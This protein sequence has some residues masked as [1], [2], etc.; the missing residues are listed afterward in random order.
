[1]Q[2]N[3]WLS[4]DPGAGGAGFGAQWEAQ[5]VHSV[6]SAIT[7]A[8]DSERSMY[9]VR[10]AISHGYN[11]NAFER[12]IYTESHDEDANGNSRVPEEIWP[13]NAGSYFSKKRSTLGAALVFTAPGIPMIFQGQEFLESGYFS[14]T[15]AL[16]WTKQQSFSGI[17]T[18]YRDMVRLRRNW[19][20]NTAG[21]KGQ[22]LNVFHVNDAE[23]VIAFHRWD[24][25]GPGDD[26]VV[27][28]NMSN[29]SF[30]SYA[31]G[32]PRDG[33]WNVR[34]NSDWSGYSAEFGNH[35]SYD[36]TAAQ[37]GQDGMP[38]SGNVGIGPY[39]AIVLSQ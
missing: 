16:D 39:T 23:K 27:V 8:D 2:S 37:P 10:D 29:Q 33:V 18:M 35:V 14:D 34:F 17:L 12:V 36:T 1:M 28:A 24:Q 20:N 11:N 4:K 21:L 30:D 31:I 13:G 15:Q 3:E 9:D 26:V 25:G 32:F 19:F 38:Y 7:A 6:R 5:F 22:S